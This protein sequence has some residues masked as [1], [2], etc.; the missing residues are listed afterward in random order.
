M[1][2]EFKNIAERNETFLS[3]LPTLT[4]AEL[5]ALILK[6]PKTWG[7]YAAFLRP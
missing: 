1:D 4:R 7:P 5:A 3:I 6:N 2:R